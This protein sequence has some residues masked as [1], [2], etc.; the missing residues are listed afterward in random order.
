MHKNCMLNSDI[1]RVLGE[2][3]HTDQLCI[4]DCGL[5]VLAGVEKIDLALKKGIP[6]FWDVLEAVAENMLVE[7]VTVA[8]EMKLHCPELLEK[9]RRYFGTAVELRFVSH[10]QLKKE[11]QCC[12]AIVRTGEMTPYANIILTAACLF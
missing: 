11:T 9:I 4:G 3:G 6:G 2:L 8:E 10:A 12:K 1:N 7:Q 5:P